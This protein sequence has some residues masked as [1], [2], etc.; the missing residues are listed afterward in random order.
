MAAVRAAGVEPHRVDAF[1]TKLA[2]LQGA[3]TTELS[4]LDAAEVRTI[5]AAA[6][7]AVSP[8]PGELRERRF[9]ILETFAS[10]AAGIGA[11]D[12]GGDGT[13]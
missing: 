8:S 11:P 6:A 7:A 3:F 4:R 13:V 1:G 2:A 5:T 10:K 12:A 9:L